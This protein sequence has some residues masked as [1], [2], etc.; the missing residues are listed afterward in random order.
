MTTIED[1][2]KLFSKIVYDKVHDEIQ[3]DFDAFEKEKEQAINEEKEKIENENKV[4]LQEAEKKAALKSNELVAKEK[5]ENQ[6]YILKLRQ[7]FINDS[8][9][10]LKKKVIKYTDDPDY[11]NFLLDSLESTLSRLDK[12][13]YDLY[14][15][16]KDI[17]NCKAEID[18]KIKEFINIKCFIKQADYDMIGGVL[19]VSTDGKMRIDNTLTSKIEDVREY[20][21]IKLTN[22]IE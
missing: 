9:E 10:E 12:G 22:E 21:G 1:K 6:Q 2:I 11:K 4:V 14:I 8:M 5:M 13:S 15:T 3:K 7:Q 20:I 16:D 17:H 18:K 19:A